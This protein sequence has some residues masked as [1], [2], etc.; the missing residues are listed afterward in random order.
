MTFESLLAE[1][2][3]ELSKMWADLVL[4]TYPKETQ[5]IWTRQKDRFQNPVGAAIFEATGE[6][7]ESLIDWQDAGAIAAS[8]D[9]LIR[10]RAVQDFT[11]SQAISFV[12]L[13]KKL[14]RD[15]Y[16]KAM[17][18][19]GTLEDLLRFEAKVD[20][21]AMMSFDIYTKSRE[22]VFRFRVD[23]VKRSQSSL[24]RKAGLVADVTV[25]TSTD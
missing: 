18:K 19:N 16:F 2:K 9:K 7:F 1:R 17:K 6:L 24:L 15:E 8:L 21:L 3:A 23:E 25:D 11:P 22:E 13:L 20:N 10:I 14:L 12:F 4:Q 5:K